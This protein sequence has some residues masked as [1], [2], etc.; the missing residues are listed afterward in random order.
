MMMM[1]VVMTMMIQIRNVANWVRTPIS[2]LVGAYQEVK[3]Q[4]SSLITVL[5]AGSSRV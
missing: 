1:M 5:Q 3:R 2:S 4:G